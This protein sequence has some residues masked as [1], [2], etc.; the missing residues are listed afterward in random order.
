MSNY[1]PVPPRVWS[2]VQNPCTFIV[3]G[4]T[5][6][7]AYIPLTGQTVPLG[8]ANYEIQ[9]LNKGNVLQYKGN[10]AR[11]TKTQKYSQLARCAG[12]NRTKVYATQ[13]QTYT[14]PNM[15][16]LLRV[17]YSSYPYPN[18]IV[19]VPNNISGPFITG[20]QNPFDC[21]TNVIQDGGTLVCGTY[22]NPC[23]GQIIQNNNGSA[24]ICNPSSASN[25]PG[26][27]I[28]CWN[29]KL[30][31]WFPKPRYF[32]NNSTSKW[33]QGYKGFISAVTPNAPVLYIV[34]QTDSTVTLAWQISSTNCIPISSYNIYQ[35]GTL[36]KNIIENTYIV[37]GLIT[38]NTYSYYV[39]ANSNSILSAPSNIV[40]IYIPPLFT[41]TGSYNF[42]NGF[43]YFTGNGTFTVNYNLTYSFTLVGGGAGGALI[44]NNSGVGLS[45]GGGGEVINSIVNFT[46]NSGE[47]CSIIIGAGGPANLNSPVPGYDSSF[48]I[49]SLTVSTN[50][51]LYSGGGGGNAINYSY[52]GGGGVGDGINSSDGG[53]YTIFANKDTGAGGAAGSLLEYSAPGIFSIT[54]PA[55]GGNN[56]SGIPGN[57][58]N[59]FQGIDGNYYG[60]GGGG[61]GYDSGTSSIGGFGGIGGGGNGG[62]INNSLIYVSSTPG[63]PNTGGGGGGAIANDGPSSLGGSGIAI[64]KF[65][66]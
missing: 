5:Y 28:L 29:N 20:L 36:I 39:T 16:G 47:T 31:S 55:Q 15:T 26:F 32:M 42:T 11:L 44:G 46:I 21:S 63:Q 23:T 49:G 6:Q 56:S 62:Y 2:R 27:S 54:L 65:Y 61:G 48:T 35:N 25:V 12:P 14:N 45:A 4:D 22:A 18:Q 60:G 10:S 24:L 38:G 53:T 66:V 3:P 51:L 8:Q 1:N 9:L 13:S 40:T 7:T 43:L 58:S 59:G 52:N 37:T 57:G 41:A 64:F 34:S 17:G 19:G 30:D 50:N 33:P